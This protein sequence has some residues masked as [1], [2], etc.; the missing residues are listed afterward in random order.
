MIKSLSDL[1][2]TKSNVNECELKVMTIKINNH[3]LTTDKGICKYAWNAIGKKEK[4]LHVCKNYNIEG[5]CKVS[6][7]QL[8]HQ[9]VITKFGSGRCFGCGRIHLNHCYGAFKKLVQYP[10]E[11]SSTVKLSPEYY[12]YEHW[13]VENEAYQTSPLFPTDLKSN[14]NM[15]C[16]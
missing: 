4:Y 9:K 8:L 3:E 13:S 16:Q 15:N 2:N 7:S 6:D 10:K 5:V 1:D 14:M 11:F 12:H